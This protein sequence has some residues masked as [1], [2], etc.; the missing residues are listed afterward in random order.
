MKKKWLIL[1]AIMPV[2]LPL[3]DIYGAVKY[4]DVDE[5]HWA[6][7]VIGKASELGL[8]VGDAQGNFNPEAE[9]DMFDA[10]KIFAKASGYSQIDATAEQKRFYTYSYEFNKKMLDTFDSRFIKWKTTSNA[11]IAFLLQRGL[12][13]SSDLNKFIVKNETEEYINKLSR[14]EFAAWL[15]SLIGA[16]VSKDAVSEVPFSDDADITTAYKPYVYYLSR[17]GITGGYADGTFRPQAAVTRASMANM[18]IGA[19][20]EINAKVENTSTESFYA[21]GTVTEIHITVERWI[22]FMETQEN[23]IISLNI[24]PGMFDIYALRCGMKVKVTYSE[25]LVQNLDIL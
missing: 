23:E 4:K 6:Y 19:L 9:V 12:L 1:F 20:A 3:N 15:V 21:E 5:K 14:Q 16:D 18:L 11:E 10:A 25:G 22:F 7:A 2:L 13:T 24:V 17:R 8:M